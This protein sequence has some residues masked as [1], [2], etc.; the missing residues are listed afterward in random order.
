NQEKEEATHKNMIE[1]VNAQS[2]SLQNLNFHMIKIQ[3]YDDTL[4]IYFDKASKS[5]EEDPSA[6]YAAITIR[7]EKV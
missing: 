4:I 2:E 3:G 7:S 1:V 6:S 5:C